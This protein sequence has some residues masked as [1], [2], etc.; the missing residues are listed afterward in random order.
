LAEMLTR[1]IVQKQ[2]KKTLWFC[3][4]KRDKASIEMRRKNTKRKHEGGGESI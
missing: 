3:L 4:E 1:D 2:K